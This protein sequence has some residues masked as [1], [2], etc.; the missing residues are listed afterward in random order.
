[1]LF[2]S[3]S[4]QPETFRSYTVQELVRQGVR[5]ETVT[6]RFNQLSADL[7]YTVSSTETERVI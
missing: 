1:M 3:V 7:V 5:V 4:I 2:R 6:E